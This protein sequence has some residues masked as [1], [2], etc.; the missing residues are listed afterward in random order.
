[1]ASRVVARRPQEIVEFTKNYRESAEE[2]ADIAARAHPLPGAPLLGCLVA[3]RRGGELG[4]GG[5]GL[6]SRSGDR[7]S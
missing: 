5:I 1:M 4:R 3:G 7:G 6:A 2:R